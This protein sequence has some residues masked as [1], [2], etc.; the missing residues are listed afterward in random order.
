MAVVLVVVK[1][2]MWVAAIIEVVVVEVIGADVLTD[3]EI[4]ALSVTVIVLKFALAVSFSVDLPSD[5]TFGLF[6]DGLAGAMLCVLNGIG[7]RV[8]ADVNAN[9]FEVVFAMT[10]AA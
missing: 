3:V 9:A 2:L 1:T 5:V 8:F 6:M 4:I 10:F 7:I